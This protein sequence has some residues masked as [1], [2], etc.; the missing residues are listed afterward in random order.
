MS[1]DFYI[2]YFL[3]VHFLGDFA[4]QTHEQSTNKNSSNHWLFLHVSVYSL[5]WLIAVIPILGFGAGFLFALITFACHF[6][7][8]WNT[9]RL[10]KPF[11]ARED[12]HNGFVIVGFDQILHYLQLWYTFKLLI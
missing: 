2:I 11:W 8:D 6:I 4:L 10:S 12:Y 7:T 5:V 3:L 9:S 1:I